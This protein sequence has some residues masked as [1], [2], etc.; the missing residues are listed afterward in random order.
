MWNRWVVVTVLGILAG[1]NRAAP[2]SSGRIDIV[3]ENANT[4]E[5]AYRRFMLA[6]LAG[7]ERA[8]RPLIVDH[9][10]AD[11]LWRDATYPKDVAAALAEQYRQMEITRA[12]LPV[13]DETP[14]RVLLESSASPVPLA[15]V[16]IGGVWKVDA[17][18]II[19]F[20]KA[21]RETP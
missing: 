14:D 2:P 16:R 1:C 6:N 19:A 15:A 5:G 3:A 11:V 7:E 10:N 4:P 17:R 8:I 20:R 18:P 12:K 13:Q 21:A 9:D